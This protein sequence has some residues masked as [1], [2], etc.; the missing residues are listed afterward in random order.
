[1]AD[2]LMVAYPGGSF[3]LE[4]FSDFFSPRPNL[5]FAKETSFS[6]SSNVNKICQISSK[7]YLQILGRF[8]KASFQPYL[9][10]QSSPS[11]VLKLFS[12]VADTTFVFSSLVFSFSG[13]SSLPI[14][15]VIFP[16]I[17]RNS[18]AITFSLKSLEAL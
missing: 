11:N 1:M 13:D 3:I 16:L 17:F 4:N 5:S 9:C 10:F 18:V 14:L 7:E 12:K 2:K 6:L 15:E 8:S